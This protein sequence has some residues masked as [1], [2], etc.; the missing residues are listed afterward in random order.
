MEKILY[1]FFFFK[2]RRS[3][4]NDAHKYIHT[5]KLEG[6]LGIFHLTKVGKQFSSEREVLFVCVVYYS[7]RCVTCV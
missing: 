2:R 3:R 1:P 6:K 7:Q 5:T 4:H